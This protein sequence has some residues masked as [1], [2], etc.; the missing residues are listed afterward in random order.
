MGQVQR[1][2][3]HWIIIVAG[4]VVAA[5]TLPYLAGILAQTP[6]W[7]F[8]GSIMDQVDYHSHLAKMWQGYRG[9]WQYHLL[10]TS[11]PHEGV[12]VQLFYVALGHVARL[13]DL[14]LPLAYQLARAGFGFVMLLAAY[15]FIALFVV[16]LR[17]RRLAFLLATM[18]SGMGWLTEVLAPTSPGG[19]SPMEFWHLDGFT[20]LA[21]LVVPHFSAA[22][23]LLLAI[24]ILLLR[25]CDGPSLKEAILAIL[26]SVAL[27]LIHPHILLLADLVPMLY[28]AAGWVRTRQPNWRGAAAVLAMGLA[29]LPILVY[30]QWIFRQPVFAGWAAQNVTLSPPLPIYL[31]AYGI[32]IVLGIVG[33]V[34]WIRCGWP[35]LAFPIIWIALVA[36]LTALPWNLQRRFVEGVQVPLGLLAGVG[37]AEGLFA[38]SSGQKAGGLRWLGMAMLIVLACMSNLVLTLGHTLAATVRSPMLFWSAD[39]IAAVDWL[40]ENSAPEDVVLAAFDVGNLI[41]GRIGH[42]VVLGHWM[43]TVDYEEKRKAV[44]EVYA[45]TTSPEERTRLL[46]LFGVSYLFFGPDE[47]ALDGFDPESADY[48]TPV[49]S[50]GQAAVYRVNLR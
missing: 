38:Q 17:T 21:V 5:S 50:R 40:G 43:E 37:M 44:G 18:A 32:L 33:I 26:C 1:S 36:V 11:E 20:Y 34:A 48:L 14:E 10:F 24:Y 19:V 28:W 31:W 15:R 22:I 39:T 9:S 23:A 13:A 41:P 2:E 16:P 12:Y 35:G 6:E 30:D 49:F 29:Q 46:S 3:W 7:I 42:R 25:R 8:R 45:A 47:R 27:G 4:L